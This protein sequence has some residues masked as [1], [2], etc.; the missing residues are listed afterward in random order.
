M[1]EEA[2]VESGPRLE[3]LWEFDLPDRPRRWLIVAAWPVDGGHA[4]SAFLFSFAPSPEGPY[5]PAFAVS[6][7]DAPKVVALPADLRGR[8]YVKVESRDQLRG[9]GRCEALCVDA[10]AI[11][12]QATA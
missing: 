5:T 10:L 4:G 12:Y 1:L 6:R 8:L 9:Q 3:H 7:P 11:S 2:A